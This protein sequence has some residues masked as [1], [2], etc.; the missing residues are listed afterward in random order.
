VGEIIFSHPAPD[1]SPEIWMELTRCP[2]C[3]RNYKTKGGILGVHGVYK[4][5]HGAGVLQEVVTTDV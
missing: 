5:R 1:S 3:L 4:V 2:V